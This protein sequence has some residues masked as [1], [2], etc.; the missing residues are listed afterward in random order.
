MSSIIACVWDFDKTLV[1]GYMEDPIFEDYNINSNEFWKETSAIA[2]RVGRE[3]GIMVNRDTYYLNRFIKY[4]KDGRFQGLNN[5]KLKEYGSK[6]RFYPGAVEIFTALKNVVDKDPKYSENDIHVEH[7]IVS[8][9]FKKIIE[10]SEFAKLVRRCWGCE[11]IDEELENG[12]KVISEIAYTIDNT[13][14]TRALFEINKGVGIHP[15]IDVNTKINEELR[16]IRFENMIYIAD[17]PSDIPAFSVINRNGG[18]SFAVYP[19]GD[20]N[21][22]RQV[23]KMRTDGRVQMFSAAN[24]EENTTTYM[25]LVNKVREF[26]D[27]ILKQQ[28]DRLMENI[29]GSTPVHLP[30]EQT[31][32][33]AE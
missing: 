32:T 19:E 29:G 25:W 16:R 15:N 13:T 30:S 33:T 18:A 8:T 2:D 11:L 1:D 24:Y 3:Q 28:K 6:L 23:E 5:E 26:A 14:K 22:F 4:A 20:F 31:E 7:Y 12:G 27:R 10:G 9:G 17:G 21:A